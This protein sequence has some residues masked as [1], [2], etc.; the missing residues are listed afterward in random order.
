VIFSPLKKS[1][2][3][4]PPRQGAQSAAC[5]VRSTAE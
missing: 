4:R 3:A 1:D 5:A 2:G